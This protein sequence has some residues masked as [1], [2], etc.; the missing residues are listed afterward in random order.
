MKNEVFAVYGDPITFSIVHHEGKTIYQLQEGELY[1]VNIKR[2][3][4]DPDSEAYSGTSDS[5]SFSLNLLT[6]PVG[7]YFFEIILIKDNGNELV[8]SP[9]ADEYGRRLNTLHITERL[10]KSNGNE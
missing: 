3:L 7:D 8:I 5:V 2:K 10:V 1:K 9:A 4:S 6:L